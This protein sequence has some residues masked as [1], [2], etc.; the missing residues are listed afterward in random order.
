MSASAERGIAYLDARVA[1]HAARNRITDRDI[2]GW[3]PPEV[4]GSIKSPLEYT[5][6]VL[7]LLHGGGLDGDTLPW[8]KTH[9]HFR[10]RSG[11][12][13]LWFG[14]NG[15]GKSAV[16]TQAAL[17]LALRGISSCLASFEM[18]PARTLERMCKQAAGNGRPTDKL[19]F[20][21]MWAINRK[22]WIYDHV[23]RIDPNMVLQ[24][25]RYAALEKG[26]RHFFVDSLMK[27]VRG[28]DDYNG[29]KNFVEDAC[30]VASETGCHV[31]L[32]HH[33]KKQEDEGSVPGKFDARGAGEITDLVH[34]VLIV[35]MNK[36]KEKEREECAKVGAALNNEMPDFLLKCD[37]QRTGGTLKT[38]GL[39]GDAQSWHFREQSASPFTRGYDIPEWQPEPGANG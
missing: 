7:A 5:E 18:L 29:Q 13:T 1:E 15:H 34:N 25:I 6:D 24:A 21:F 17:W 36:A 26:V 19:V 4:E 10:F 2:R 11:E 28:S 37:K 33:S 31:H 27:C 14:I 22:I 16:T 35:W 39:W 20:D 32:I 9:E 12:V 38:W 3:T 30:G 8:L 23:G